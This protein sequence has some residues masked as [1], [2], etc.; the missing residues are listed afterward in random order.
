M[1]APVVTPD[2]LAELWPEVWP[3]VTG[4]MVAR[5]VT[6][7]AAEDAVAEAVLRCLTRDVVA[8]DAADLCRWIYRTAENARIDAVR[9]VAR[10]VLVAAPPCGGTSRD[11][12]DVVAQRAD[13]DATVVALRS[14]SDDD[15]DAILCRPQ[16]LPRA[17]QLRLGLRRRRARLKLV[18]AG[19]RDAD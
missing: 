17:E 6:R 13:V 16:R 10:S 19:A 12:A 11:P 9:R 5:G 7:A 2:R 3:T 15:R 14:L 18:R 1:D 4:T 8:H